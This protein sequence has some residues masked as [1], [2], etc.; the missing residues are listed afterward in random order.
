MVSFIIDAL[1]LGG[2]GA[3]G[4]YDG[5]HSNATATSQNRFAHKRPKSIKPRRTMAT[6]HK[7][8]AVGPCQ[9]SR[10][11]LQCAL[12]PRAIKGHISVTRRSCHEDVPFIWSKQGRGETGVGGHSPPELPPNLINP[13]PIQKIPL[14]TQ[15]ATTL[16]AAL[17]P[18]RAII[19]VPSLPIG[20]NWFRVAFL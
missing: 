11:N 15:E 9:A 4:A 12:P 13:L 3:Q 17:A 8:R 7:Q 14:G 16:T 20:P 6:N 10:S 1:F 19:H 5:S 18:R 2:V